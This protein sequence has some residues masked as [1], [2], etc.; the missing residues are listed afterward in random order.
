MPVAGT[1]RARVMDPGRVRLEDE[2]VAV[3]FEDCDFTVLE[4]AVV[5]PAVLVAVIV[6]LLFDRAPLPRSDRVFLDLAE[7]AAAGTP[8]RSTDQV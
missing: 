3:A 1:F 5:A 4:R 7:A 2:A 8:I 6:L